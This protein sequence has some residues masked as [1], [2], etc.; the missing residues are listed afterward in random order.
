MRSTKV[1]IIYDSS[2]PN[3]QF[4]KDVDTKLFNENLENF[5]FTDLSEG[6]KKVYKSAMRNN[7]NV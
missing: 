7:F 6:I 5:E 3:G 1:K 2:K 4:R